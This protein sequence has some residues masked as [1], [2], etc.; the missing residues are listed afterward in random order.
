MILGSTC[1]A[2]IKTESHWNFQTFKVAIAKQEE[3]RKEWRRQS[4][5]WENALKITPLQVTFALLNADDISYVH[6]YLD[7]T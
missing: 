2:A 7:G 4:S 5:K 6:I 3:T 1:D